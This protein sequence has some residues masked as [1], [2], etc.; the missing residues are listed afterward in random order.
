M[1]RSLI[2][3]YFKYCGRLLGELFKGGLRLEG[4]SAQNAG[5]R[6]NSIGMMFFDATVEERWEA[7]ASVRESAG[8]WGIKEQRVDVILIDV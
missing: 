1:K 4:E 3:I 8:W 5:G 7:P 6:L 2:I